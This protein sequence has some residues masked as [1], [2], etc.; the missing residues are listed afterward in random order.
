M[1]SKIRDRIVGSAV[2]TFA[3]RGFHGTST[4]EI[5]ILAD[6]TEGS[7]F[8]LCKSKE[9][10]FSESVSTVCACKK[11]RP[12]YSRLVIFAL[13]EEKGIDA[14]NLRGIRRAAK[15]CTAVDAVLKLTRQ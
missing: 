10:L 5:A 8:R 2:K 15:F 7:L 3:R 6:V 12:L 9:H 14:D 1:T 11:W 4:K 13:L